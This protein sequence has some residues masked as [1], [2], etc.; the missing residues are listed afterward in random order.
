MTEQTD[1][2]I[3][4]ARDP[5]RHSDA[6]IDAIIEKMREARHAFNTGALG[7]KPKLTKKEEEVAKAGLGLS[8]KLE[9][10]K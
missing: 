5:L 3:L 8:L 4:F 7:A 2:A 10:K 6:D 1:I 9:L